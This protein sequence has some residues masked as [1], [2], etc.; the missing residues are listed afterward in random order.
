MDADLAA[1]AIV[2]ILV[3]DQVGSTRFNIAHGDGAAGR[4]ATDHIDAVRTIANALGGSLEKSTGDGALVSFKL[5]TAALDAAIEIQRTMERL[6]R[7]YVEPVE[8]RVGIAVGEVHR[9]HG[10]MRG[11]PLIHATRL[12]DA[13]DDGSILVSKTLVDLLATNSQHTLL[14]LLELDLKG[15]DAPSAAWEVEWRLTSR[16]PRI[17]MNPELGRIDER[18]W[19]GREEELSTLLDSVLAAKA[20]R[21]VVIGGEPGAGKTRLVARFATECMQQD[22]LVVYGAAPRELRSSYVPLVAALR[23]VLGSL[24]GDV[25]AALLAGNTGRELARLLP[26]LGGVGREVLHATDGLGSQR[27]L[28]EAISDAL[29]QLSAYAGGLT[30]V[31][32]DL[33]WADDLTIA[34]LR[35]ITG[36]SGPAGVTVVAAVRSTEPEMP[37]EFFADVARRGEVV[38]IDLGGL[39][40]E[41]I[42]TLVAAARPGL[43]IG[44]AVEAASLIYERTAGNALFVT[45]L[46]GESDSF[47]QGDPMPDDAGLSSELSTAIQERLARFDDDDLVALS[48]AAVVG[49]Q[50]AATLWGEI[51]ELVPRDIAALIRR[52]TRA[53]IVHEIGDGIVEFSHDLV[54]T[55]LLPA[56]DSYELAVV[57]H[58]IA[59]VMA[60]DPECEPMAVASHYLASL[61]ARPDTTSV[62]QWCRTAAQ[63]ASRQLAYLDAASYYQSALDVLGRDDER[64]STLLVEL[65]K[66]QRYGG[67][68]NYRST[69][70]AAI[71]ECLDDGRP[72][73]AADAALANN[74]GLYSSA[75]AA[76]RDRIETLERVLEEEHPK[77]VRSELLATLAVERVFVDDREALDSLS[78]EAVSLGRE[79]G[80]RRALARALSFRQDT[81]YRIDNVERRLVETD[82]LLALTADTDL[83][84]RFWALAHRTITVGEVG[85]WD[86]VANLVEQASHVASATRQPV[87]EWYAALLQGAYAIQSG[88]LRKAQR[89]IDR[90]YELGLETAQPDALILTSG[91]QCEVLRRRG[92]YAT[93]H[94]LAE[95]NLDPDL[96]RRSA[97][98][99]AVLLLEEGRVDDAVRVWEADGLHGALAVPAA[100]VGHNLLHARRMCQ[101][102]GDQDAL[103]T[104]EELLADVPPFLFCNYWEPTSKPA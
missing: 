35:Y 1:G 95:M 20:A 96:L 63:E 99:R 37:T 56:A 86:D 51:A 97:P 104:I 93:I 49:Q 34:V 89:T 98:M 26:E 42:T 68:S 7:R 52:A 69:L 61:P 87:L 18:P 73:L 12:C 11:W 78:A 41:D 43:D 60:A 90:G 14:R 71:G 64:R 23:S 45:S 55:A 21:L 82:E 19:C 77:S 84:G 46:V 3:V 8:V 9:H 102:V 44:Q 38:Q 17:R 88:E 76:D 91:Q 101:V 31:V 13:A 6:S 27:L 30:L 47:R 100:Q 75:G 25:I 22:H 65:G 67:D 15:L 59:E 32:D 94:E 50:F 70:L 40:V 28:I 85:R 36:P 24:D 5:G 53:G 103:E 57:H 72:D 48:M 10:E 16:N 29:G 58:T 66:S 62:V 4:V 39:P 92:R 79:S 74:R 33:Q 2:A 81:N 54:R 83:V 80:D